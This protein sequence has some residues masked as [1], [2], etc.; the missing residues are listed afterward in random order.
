MST[1]RQHDRGLRFALFGLF[2]LFAMLL[3]GS[4]HRAEP[5]NDS[6]S[7]RPATIAAGM[8]MEIPAA[9]RGAWDEA[10]RKRP[11]WLLQINSESRNYD[12]NPL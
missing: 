6:N 3:I 9:E 11:L 7:D 2:A 4:N 10:S 1:V 8:R 12:L 5:V